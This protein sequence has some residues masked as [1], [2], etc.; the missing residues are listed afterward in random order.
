MQ[1]KNQGLDRLKS[2]HAAKRN[3]QLLRFWEHDVTNN[4]FLIIQQLIDFLKTDIYGK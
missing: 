1:R 3:F 4:R 2:I